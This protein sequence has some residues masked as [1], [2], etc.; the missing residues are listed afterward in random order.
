MEDCI[1]CKI[2][3][4]KVACKLIYEDED[5]MAFLDINPGAP[6]HTLVIP[7][8]HYQTIFEMPDD[9]AC[10]FFGTVKK[11]S[12][13]IDKVIQPDGVNLFQNNRSAAGQV[14]NHIHFH[15]FP[16]FHGDAIDFKWR[17]IVLD[18]DDLDRM[19]EKIKKGVDDA[20]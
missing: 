4:K 7:K 20:A 2:V 3:E 18:S 6:G 10:K 9:E 5:T 8:K 14:I 15:I 19:V 12:N 13:A 11:I 16:R 1:F 17:R